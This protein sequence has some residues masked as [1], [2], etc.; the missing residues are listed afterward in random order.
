MEIYAVNTGR[1]LHSETFLNLMQYIDTNKKERIKKYIRFED[2]C[3]VLVAD[4]LARAVASRM[5]GVSN[6]DI[7]FG[8]G[9]HGK[10][11][12]LNTNNYHFS[13]AHSKTWVVC[14]ADDCEVGIDVEKIRPI[15]TMIAKRFF[16]AEEYD[17]LLNKPSNEQTN[18][19]FDLW[20]LKESYVKALGKGL[21]LPFNSFRI[22][23]EDE[24]IS[25]EK[26]KEVKEE[27]AGEDAVKGDNYS[28]KLYHIDNYNKMA[29]CSTKPEQNFP[30]KINFLSIDELP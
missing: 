12:I 4:V 21:L 6:N 13:I 18:Y 1:K 8:I 3:R 28:F 30:E 25:I 22:K 16:T 29:V 2:A 9:K 26:G 15:N 19:F 14:A 23:I 5:L 7:S 27:F 20:T 17:E 24:T 10:P 11:Y